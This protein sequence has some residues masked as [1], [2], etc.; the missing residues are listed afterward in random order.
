MATSDLLSDIKD[1]NELIKNGSSW[2]VNAWAREHVDPLNADDIFDANNIEEHP[3]TIALMRGD[4]DVLEVVL[5][6]F[7]I[8]GTA[9]LEH[10]LYN[11]K[12]PVETIDFFLQKMPS[13]H[14][15]ACFFQTL[16]TMLRTMYSKNYFD[17]KDVQSDAEKFRVL[18]E[19]YVRQ[20][21]AYDPNSFKNNQKLMYNVHRMHAAI[22]SKNCF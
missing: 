16:P 18:A 19:H 11:G 21:N 2:E 4:H 6:M 14:L 5:D 8:D 17:I 9:I 7:E 22:L 20:C 10:V 1:L 13:I 3:V 12:V 15:D